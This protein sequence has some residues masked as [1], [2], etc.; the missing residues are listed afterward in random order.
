MSNIMKAI[1][2]VKRFC[3]RAHACMCVCVCAKGFFIIFIEGLFEEMK[4]KLKPKNEKE[5]VM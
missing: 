3:V 2:R 1:N 5:P 4:I